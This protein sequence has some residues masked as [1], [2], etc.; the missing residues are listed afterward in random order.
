MFKIYVAKLSFNNN[1]PQLVYLTD[2]AGWAEFVAQ[3]FFFSF[4]NEGFRSV[5]SFFVTIEYNLRKM[6][7]A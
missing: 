3:A 7:K 2:Y 4:D 5:M 6:G 1:K